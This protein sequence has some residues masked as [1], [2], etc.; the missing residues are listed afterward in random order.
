MKRSALLAVFFQT[1]AC[2]STPA[3]AAPEPPAT[4]L[5][6]KPLSGPFASVSDWCKTL[7]A[8]AC[9]ERKDVISPSMGKPLKTRSGVALEAVTAAY[10]SG[11]RQL[12]VTLLRRGAELFPLPPVIEYDPTDKAQHLASIFVFKQYDEED[13][14]LI[15]LTHNVIHPSKASG[16]PAGAEDTDYLTDLC[17]VKQGKPIACVRV[18]T[19]VGRSWP[20]AADKEVAGAQ[21]LLVIRGLRVES[22]LIQTGAPAPDLAA[23]LLKNGNYVLQFP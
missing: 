8:D 1:V 5:Q 6:G 9:E 13:P 15:T 12:G 23:R 19:E 22:R 18:T 7:A 14:D 3:P 17:S 10:R 16:V 20:G 4:V 2:T 11:S 21:T